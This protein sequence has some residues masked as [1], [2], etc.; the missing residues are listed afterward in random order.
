MGSLI[1]EVGAGEEETPDMLRSIPMI[2]I[3]YLVLS[4]I[5]GVWTWVELVGPGS[6]DIDISI[7]W[8]AAYFFMRAYAKPLYFA[9]LMTVPAM[10][11][12]A[13]SEHLKFR[14][15]WQHVLAAA[16]VSMAAIWIFGLRELDVGVFVEWPERFGLR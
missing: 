12:I 13:A 3:G 15:A 11:W 6:G 16:L 7:D 5:P 10:I 4:I 9:G 14:R 8:K 1:R 2:V